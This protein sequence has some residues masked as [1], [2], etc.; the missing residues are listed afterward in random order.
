[1]Q[2]CVDCTDAHRIGTVQALGSFT[3]LKCSPRPA[4]TLDA[5]LLISKKFLAHFFFLR[6]EQQQHNTVSNFRVSRLSIFS[7]CGNNVICKNP[8]RAENS[9]LTMKGMRRA[10]Y[11]SLSPQTQAR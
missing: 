10:L 4:F 1:M 5:A 11:T 9:L 7:F 2:R 3:F 6:Q 8:K